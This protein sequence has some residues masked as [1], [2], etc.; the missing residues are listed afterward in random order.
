MELAQDHLV[1]DDDMRMRQQLMLKELQETHYT[2]PPT[3]SPHS[4]VH[5]NRLI[6]NEGPPH[7]SKLCTSSS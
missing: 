6:L 4:L 1:L 2:N 5:H 7:P 3:L